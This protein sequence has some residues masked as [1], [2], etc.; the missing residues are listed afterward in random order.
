MFAETLYTFTGNDDL[1]G[2]TILD[3]ATDT[4]NTTQ[5]EIYYKCPPWPFND[6]V[7]CIKDSGGSF[8]WRILGNAVEGYQ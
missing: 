2:R 5:N 1:F 7:E 4:C 3:M 6:T 8:A